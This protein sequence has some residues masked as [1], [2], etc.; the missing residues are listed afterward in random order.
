MAPES[1]RF[2]HTADLHLDVPIHAIVDAPRAVVD[3]MA[4]LSSRLL[5]RIMEIAASEEVQFVLL[6]G[7][8]I[9]WRLAGPALC[10]EWITF[11]ETVAEQ[12][13]PIVWATSTAERAR[14]MPASLLPRGVVFLSGERPQA[15]DCSLENGTRIVFVHWPEGAAIPD[16]E[17]F[18]ASGREGDYVI[19]VRHRSGREGLPGLVPLDYW[20][21]GGGHKKQTELSGTLTLHDPGTPLARR[22][23][24]ADNPSV[25]VVTLRQG[26]T[27]DLRPRSTGLL[28]WETIP[29]L[30]TDTFSEAEFLA[31][32]IQEWESRRQ[33]AS[34]EALLRFEACGDPVRMI[35]WRR[36]GVFDR[37]LAEL[38]SRC[39]RDHGSPWPLGIDFHPWEEWPSEWLNED[40]FR[41]ELLRQTFAA[42]G[43]LYEETAGEVRDLPEELRTEL[44]SS[45]G[46]DDPDGLGRLV[47][48]AVL[49]RLRAAEDGS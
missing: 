9:D 11:C 1:L 27:C 15:T 19:A 17:A 38:R 13:I 8:V 47:A 16:S 6:A 43:D 21:L 2:L 7:D 24:E 39:E 14:P 20:A 37:V 23:G 46:G 28:R 40:S 18:L 12:G 42:P 26:D 22:P 5:Q 32:A 10:E 49:E 34:G 41:G 30:V 45:L 35:A 4:G 3:R 25:T 31:Q 48:V 33:S 44:Q 36:E 29:L